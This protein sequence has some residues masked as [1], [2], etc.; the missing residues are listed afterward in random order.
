M[1]VSKIILGLFILTIVG[2][3]IPRAGFGQTEN[4]GDV[5]YTAPKDWVKTP[6]NNIVSFTGLNQTNGQFCIITLYGATKATGN[7]KSDFAREWKNL[8]ADPFQGEASP[9]TETDSADG[10]TITAGGSLIEFQ[11]IKS[12][13]FLTVYSGF[14]RTVSI[15]GVF[16][17]QSFLPQLTAFI[18]SVNIEKPTP[19]TNQGGQSNQPQSVYVYGRLAISPPGRQLTLA[20]LAGNWGQDDGINTRYVFKSTGTYAGSDSLHFTSKMTIASDGGY[21]NDF[22]ALEN[23]TTIREEAPGT[24]SIDGTVLT[25]RVKTNTRYFIIRGWWE[26]PDMTIMV[27]CQV[28]EEQIQDFLKVSDAGSNAT[29]VR[30]K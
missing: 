1:K 26:L 10:W 3:F 23:N 21:F 15:L 2:L 16:N 12:M 29:W 11:G 18:S 24:I 7:P 8:V 17:D 20:D 19:V 28:A 4:L 27:I 22:F 30:K 14:E 25:V 13:A 6:K 5:S 9:E